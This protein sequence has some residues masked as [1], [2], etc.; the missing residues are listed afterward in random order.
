MTSAPDR[1]VLATPCTA[2]KDPDPTPLPAWRRYLGPRV[3]LVRQ[4][5]RDEERRA[6][7]LSGLLGLVAMEALVPLYDHLLVE[8]EVAQQRPRV[9]EQLKEAGVEEMDFLHRPLGVDPQLAPYLR[10]IVEACA[11]AGVA[12]RLVELKALPGND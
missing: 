2:F 9:V 4:R 3:A 7:V 6:F 5:A 12:L 1:R 8:E 11:L 10:L